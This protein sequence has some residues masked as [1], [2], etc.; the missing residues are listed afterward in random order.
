[1]SYK[2]ILDALQRFGTDNLFTIHVIWIMFCLMT[3]MLCL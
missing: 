3:E 1:M 2:V